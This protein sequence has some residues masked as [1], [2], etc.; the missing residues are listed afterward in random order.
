MAKPS[1]VAARHVGRRQHDDH[2]PGGAARRPAPPLRVGGARRRRRVAAAALGDAAD[3]QP[4]DPVR[5]RHRRHRGAAVLHAG[6]RR[7][8]TSPAAA[9]ARPADA[10]QASATRRTRRCSTRCCSTSRASASS[11]WATRRRWRSSCSCR[12]RRHGADPA[13]LAAL[14]ALPGGGRWRARPPTPRRRPRALVRRRP[15]RA[16]RRKRLL[17]A[18]ADHSL[19]IALAIAFLAP[20]VF[21]VADLADDRRPGAVVEAVAAPVPVEQLH[22]RLPRRRRSG[23]TRPTRCSTPGSSTIGVLV[24]SIPVAYALSRLRWRGR[25]AVF[26][27][28]LVAHDA[29]G[30]GH[31]R[32]ALRDVVQAAPGRLAD[33]R[34]S[35]PT[36]SATRSRS[37]CC[38][39]S[40]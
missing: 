9:Q 6:L 34:S 5:R 4:G 32:A 14:G 24:S 37:S 22:R 36:G 21:M 28:V 10:G 33:G 16:V 40:S 31:R 15:P 7:R 30:A 38:A 1:L 12:V 17:I 18:V 8:R 19:L 3:D 13:Q 26:L 39:S 35:C 20:F 2:L 29:A 27:L 11:T 23:A 25:D